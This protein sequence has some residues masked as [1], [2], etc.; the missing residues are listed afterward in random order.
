MRKL[1]VESNHPLLFSAW[2]KA[3]FPVL[4]KQ[5]VKASLG[6]K[7]IK[8]NGKR[9]GDDVTLFPGDEVT[10][11]IDDAKLDGPPIEVV[12]LSGNIVAAVKPVGMLSKAEG[13]ADMEGRVSQWLV[14]QGEQSFAMACHRLD[15]QTGGIMLFAR[16]AETEIAVRTLMEEGK[17]TKT[18]HCI[19]QGTP[20][21]DHAVLTAWLRKDAARA[22]VSVLDRPAPGARTAITEYSVLKTDGSRSLLEVR[23]HTGRTHQI[24]AHLASVGHPILGDDKYGNRE[25]NRQFKARRQKLWA[26][27]LDFTFSAEK[28]PLLQELENKTLSSM[29]PFDMDI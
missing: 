1:T 5:A 8:I 27:R 4:S 20:N 6:E 14:G 12:F 7:S 21:P 18:Y 3:V 9:T 15:S 28:Y 19:V 13:E 10:L 16:N 23:L 26:C 17:I 25:F 29:A 22:F 2:M 24:R 11:F